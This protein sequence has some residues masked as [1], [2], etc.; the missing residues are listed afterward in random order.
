[1]NRSPTPVPR[2]HRHFSG[3]PHAPPGIARR[4]L[5]GP[6]SANWPPICRPQRS[7]NAHASIRHHCPARSKAKARRTR[8]ARALLLL[9]ANQRLLFRRETSASD[10]EYFTPFSAQPDSAEKTRRSC[11]IGSAT[12][13]RKPSTRAQAPLHPLDG[14]TGGVTRRCYAVR[15]PTTTR[16]RPRA[17]LYTSRG[18]GR[19][20]RADRRVF[21]T[22]RASRHGLPAGQR[23]PPGSRFVAAT[24]DARKF[25][26]AEDDIIHMDDGLILHKETVEE[27]P[28]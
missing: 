5:R 20:R 10:F 14:L 23:R 9:P 19:L 27:D 6:G 17:P 7:W 16:S 28:D 1:M 8:S 4:R 25:H 12:K 24:H 22:R 13:P 26:S 18:C 3:R 15:R 21:T 2:R 11:C